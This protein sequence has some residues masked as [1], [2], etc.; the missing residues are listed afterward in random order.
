MFMYAVKIETYNDASGN[1]R[2]GYL[3]YDDTGNLV[4]FA[5]E[6]YDEQSRIFRRLSETL[7]AEYGC[8]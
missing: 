6:D 1:P 7:A 3:V 8:P 5:D 2:R 4:G